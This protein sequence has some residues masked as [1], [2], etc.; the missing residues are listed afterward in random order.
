MS[1]Q[2]PIADMLT[3]IRNAQATGG[4]DVRFPTSNLKKSILE[5]LKRE[6]YVEDKKMIISSRVARKPIKIPAGVDVK[7]VG[8]ELIVKGPKG[9]IHT[10]VHPSVEILVEKDNVKVQSATLKGTA[11]LAANARAQKALS[12]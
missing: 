1:M 2:D 12:G 7:L 9:Q 10:P 5:V 3:R 6:G 4:L 8:A 11:R